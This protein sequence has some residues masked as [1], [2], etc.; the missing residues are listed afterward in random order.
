MEMLCRNLLAR[1]IHSEV[2][3]VARRYCFHWTIVTEIYAHMHFVPRFRVELGLILLRTEVAGLLAPFFGRPMIYYQEDR[4]TERNA[5][6]ESHC[7][8]RACAS[9]A[10]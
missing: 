3:Y 10:Y 9:I 4:R 7:G 5:R 2:F 8:G 6:A 1:P